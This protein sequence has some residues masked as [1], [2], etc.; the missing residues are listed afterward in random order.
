[1]LDEATAWMTPRLGRPHSFIAP[2]WGY[3]DGALEAAAERGLPTWTPPEPAPLLDG[4]LVRETLHDG[5][6]GLHGLDYSPLAE[7]AASGVPPTV[8]FHGRLLDGRVERLRAAGEFRTLARLGAR[9]DLERIAALRGVRWVGA[10]ELVE[11]L[12]AHDSIEPGEDGPL[13]PDGVEAVVLHPDGR[14]EA[15]AAA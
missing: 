3:S 13:I 7:L 11:R 10:A 5:L 1:M 9:R 15:L 14:R 12:R 8:V 4:V 2:A 6:P